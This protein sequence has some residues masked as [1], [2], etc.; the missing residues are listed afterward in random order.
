[1][2]DLSNISDEEIKLYV[3]NEKNKLITTTVIEKLLESYGI[4]Y[5]VKH[6]DRFQRAM[7]HISYLNKDFKNDK[8]FKMTYIC[9][10]NRERELEPIANPNDA[11]PLQD[12]SYERL[13]FLGDSVIHLALADY[14]FHRYE[15]QY[16]GF[17]TRLRTK[18]ENGQTLSNLAKV[19]NLHEYVLISRNIEHSG[20]RQKNTHIL[21]DSFESF[22]GALYIDGTDYDCDS[23]CN[24]IYEKITALLSETQTLSKKVQTSIKNILQEEM[25]KWIINN[26]ILQSN[27][28]IC[29]KFVIAVIE[30]EIDIAQLLYHETNYKDSLLQY[31][32]K[33]KWSDPEYE[34]MDLIGPEYQKQFKM[35]VKGPGRVIVGVGAGS[36][37]KKGEQEAAKQALTY[38]G[39]IKSE[40]EVDSDNELYGSDDEMDYISL[41]SE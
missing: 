41:D 37:K 22:I 7:T 14:L 32:H 12:A 20:G 19:L 38:F 3:L 29:K 2:T 31:Y 1:M 6:L 28:E 16:E 24:G 30:D 39:V 40:V 11:I 13:E 9:S 8:N 10:N 21:E 36:S 34:M 5:K 35:C 18:L 27:F 15:N 26:N 23:L 4:S 25:Q 17:M 33:M